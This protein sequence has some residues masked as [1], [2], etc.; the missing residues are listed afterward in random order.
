M[1]KNFNKVL[2]SL[3]F[4]VAF[5]YSAT[6]AETIEDTKS[7]L[8]ADE[9]FGTELV[10]KG[11]AFKSPNTHRGNGKTTFRTTSTTSNK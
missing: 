10:K 8:L 11:L 5:N 6:H 4:I 9:Q 3:F 7:R 2:G 1:K